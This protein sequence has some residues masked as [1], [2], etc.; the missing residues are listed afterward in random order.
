[1]AFRRA[2]PGLHF[3]DAMKIQDMAPGCAEHVKLLSDFYHAEP[4]PS[5]FTAGYRE[6]PKG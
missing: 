6:W 2:P 3:Q 4:R 1:M 5:T